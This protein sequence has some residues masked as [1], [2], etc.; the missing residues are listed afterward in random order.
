MFFEEGNYERGLTGVTATVHK[1][2]LIL[3]RAVC[4]VSGTETPYQEP[5][6]DVFY[7]FHIYLLDSCTGSGGFLV[8]TNLT[9]FVIH[10]SFEVYDDGDTGFDSAC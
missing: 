3:V 5:A 7:P 10:I 8:N 1:Y 2:I 6:R 4:T 9:Q